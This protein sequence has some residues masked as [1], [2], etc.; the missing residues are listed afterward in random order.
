VKD[1]GRPPFADPDAHRGA[2]GSGPPRLPSWN[3]AAVR[4]E[5]WN[6]VPGGYG[7][8][9]DVASAP[10]WLRLWFRTPFLDRWAYPR[11]VERGFGYLTPRPGVPARDREEI[12]HGWRLSPEGWEPPGAE[13]DLR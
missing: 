13:T 8:R 6:H 12:P 11:L 4:L 1:A 5:G 10:W 2:S 7:A 3:T 9:F